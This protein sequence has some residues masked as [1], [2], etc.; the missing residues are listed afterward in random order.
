MAST[1]RRIA[2]T[3]Q[4]GR[5]PDQDQIV[6][7]LKTLPVSGKGNVERSVMKY[8]ITRALLMYIQS[9]ISKNTSNTGPAAMPHVVSASAPVVVSP[10]VSH[11]GAQ[12]PAVP[13]AP[14]KPAAG[15]ALRNKIA[16]SMKAGS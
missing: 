1:N 15:S 11:Q 13:A 8:H 6:D 10:V 7:W 16:K 9:G 4:S 14:A 5:D 2:A 3:F 12:V